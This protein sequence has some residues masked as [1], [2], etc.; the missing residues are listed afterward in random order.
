MGEG[1]GW[2]RSAD[3][4]GEARSLAELCRSL[5]IHAPTILVL[6]DHVHCNA[7]TLPGHLPARFLHAQYHGIRLGHI[8]SCGLLERD[9]A[10]VEVEA[11]LIRDRAVLTCGIMR[12]QG[13]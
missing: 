10:S 9:L 13:P 1:V 5:G 6:L 12:S 8:S 2:R 4:A 11:V 7:R 3:R